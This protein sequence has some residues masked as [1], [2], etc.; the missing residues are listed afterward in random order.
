MISTW[1]KHGA[2]HS[3]VRRD[4]VDIGRGVMKITD[5]EEVGEDETAASQCY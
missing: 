3:R 5:V 4:Y 1:L 2:P